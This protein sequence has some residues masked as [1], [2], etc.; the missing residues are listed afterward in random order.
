MEWCLKHWDKYSSDFLLCL[1]KAV[2]YPLLTLLYC[3]INGR[4]NKREWTQNTEFSI[5]CSLSFPSLAILCFCVCFLSL[6]LLP[7]IS[8]LYASTLECKTS[9]WV[10]CSKSHPKNVAHNILHIEN[11]CAL[12]IMI[13]LNIITCVLKFKKKIGK[14]KQKHIPMCLTRFCRYVYSI[15]W[16]LNSP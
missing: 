7:K 11:M 3:G 13:N 9:L 5:P 4:K 16:V 8:N 10:D 14:Q 2:F 12:K 15:P 1:V 6:F